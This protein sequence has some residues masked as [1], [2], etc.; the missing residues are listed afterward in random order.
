MKAQAPIEQDSAVEQACTAEKSHSQR[1]LNPVCRNG[2]EPNAKGDKLYCGDMCR[3][4]SS[5]I[6]RAAVLLVLIGKDEAW[7]IIQGS[8]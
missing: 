6:R 8:K 3:Q 1:C 2:V 4:A 5:I 7:K